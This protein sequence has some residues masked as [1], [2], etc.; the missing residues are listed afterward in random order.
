[1]Q[2]DR[3]TISIAAVIA[4]LALGAFVYSRRAAADLSRTYTIGTDR[5]YPYHDLDRQGRPRGFVTEVLNEA[6]KRRGIRL[7]WRAVDKRLTE[8]LRDGDVD[9]WPLVS[10]DLRRTHPEFHLTAPWLHNDFAFVAVRSE[11]RD[12]ARAPE[13]RKVA[14]RPV[15]APLAIAKEKFPHAELAGMERREAIEAVCRGEADGAIVELRVAHYFLASPP[16]ACQNTVPCFIGLTFR[17]ESMVTASRPEFAA[18]ADMMRTEIGEMAEDGTLDRILLPW[19]YY[20]T[21]EI[22]SIFKVEQAEARFRWALLATAITFILMGAFFLQ[23]RRLWTEQLRGEIASRENIAKTVLLQRVSHELRTPL[24]GV[25]TGLTLLKPLVEEAKRQDRRSDGMDLFRMIES[26]A[27][28][29][30]R[31]IG[32]LLDSSRMTRDAGGL[33]IQAG[34]MPLRRIFV[35]TAQDFALRV[36]KKGVA[37]RTPRLDAL[38]EWAEGDEVRFRQL[39]SGLLENG[40]GRTNEGFIALRA[41]VRETE[42]GCRLRIEAEDSGNAMT[43]EEAKRAFEPFEQLLKE[44]ASSGSSGG[45]LGLGL[46]L[47]REIALRMGGEAGLS[48]PRPI[49][50]VFWVEIPLRAAQSPVDLFPDDPPSGESQVITPHSGLSAPRALRALVVDDDPV[51]RLLISRLLIKMDC[52]TEMAIDGREAVER[53]RSIPFDLVVMDCWMPVVDGF[54]ASR[55]IR[56]MGQPGCTIIGCT[57]NYFP[58]EIEKC[59]LAGM[60]DVLPKPIDIARLRGSVETARRAALGAGV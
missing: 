53:A 2:P 41:A 25:V 54:E 19:A 31:L 6:A 51:N 7:E 59:K 45:G 9:L 5:V 10:T 12:P 28:V 39:L 46:A 38:P 35:E 11:W 48:G 44:D 30:S 13:V 60:D 58:E 56:A 47:A 16:P 23:Q 37:L 14:L 21:E 33:E 18:V 55:Q 52:E 43:P 20:Q 8:A 24:H 57:A 3:R 22:R 15:A 1:M 40:L 17:R 27:A 36:H 50:C 26:A 49:G 34:V 42:S 4:I 32:D 29:L